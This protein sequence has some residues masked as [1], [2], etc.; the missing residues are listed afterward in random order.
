MRDPLAAWLWVLAV[1]CGAGVGL[2]AVEALVH[3]RGQHDGAAF[4]AAGL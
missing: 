1:V 3:A 2:A 4:V